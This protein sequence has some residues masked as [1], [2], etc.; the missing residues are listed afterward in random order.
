M[1]TVVGQGGVIRSKIQLLVHR[2]VFLRNV[3]QGLI[4]RSFQR[5]WMEMS[6]LK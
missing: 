4:Q 3:D 1:M 5:T 2:E 6:E